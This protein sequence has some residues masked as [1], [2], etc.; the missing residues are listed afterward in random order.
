MSKERSLAKRLRTSALV[1]AMLIGLVISTVLLVNMNPTEIIM[2]L[3]ERGWKNFASA[4]GPLE[5]DASGF[6]AFY[7]YP[8]QGTPGTAYATN[9][10][11]ASAYEYSDVL[12]A[13][14]TG[15]TPYDT[16]FD[17]VVKFR[18]NDTVGYNT[19][20]STWE[21]SWV[22]VYITVNFEFAADQGNT[23]M[24][25]VEITNT[26]SFCWYHGYINN[27]AAG[28]TITKNEAYNVTD[29]CGQGYW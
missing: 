15:E 24:T 18:V 22:R 19:S 13:E 16:A 20:G 4:D 28:Y 25:I 21:I 8:H 9:L 1:S 7:A 26:S 14:M 17:F 23:T 12:N 29:L 27:A 11:N 10:S 2:S 5:G 6:L 3:G